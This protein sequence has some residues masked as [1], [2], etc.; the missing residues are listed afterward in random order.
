VPDDVA[1]EG[2]EEE[3]VLVLVAAVVVVEEDGRSVSPCVAPATST[4]HVMGTA[5]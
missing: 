1:K 3:M 4:R 2:L 5:S